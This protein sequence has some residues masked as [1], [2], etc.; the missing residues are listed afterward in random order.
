MAKKGELRFVDSQEQ[1]IRDNPHH[2]SVVLFQ[3]ASSI[4]HT[5]I[6]DDMLVAKTYAENTL[7][8]ESRFRTAMLYAANQ[9]GNY[10]L[11]STL[12]RNLKWKVVVPS[13][14]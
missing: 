11:V 14:Y 7:Q 3:P 12:G 6:F 1:T 13:T 9:Y 10:A 2:Y 8:E 4:R 5:Q